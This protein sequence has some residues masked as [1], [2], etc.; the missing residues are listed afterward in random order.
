M[1]RIKLVSPEEAT[2]K[3][4]EIFDEIEQARGK[5]RV[6]NL[7]RAYANHL[8]SLE[9]NWERTKRLMKSGLLPRKLKEAIGLTMAAVHNCHY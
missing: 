3:V 4:K 9:L 5:G 8:P 2:G 6:S 1:A 7:F